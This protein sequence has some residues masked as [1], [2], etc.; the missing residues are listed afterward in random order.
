MNFDMS[1]IATGVCFCQKHGFCSFS[2][3]FNTKLKEEK[4]EEKD[5]LMNRSLNWLHCPSECLIPSFGVSQLPFVWHLISGV[6]GSV[7]MIS[8]IL[9]LYSFNAGNANK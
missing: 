5:L 3:K 2:D 1:L 4:K 7:G 6:F 8:L 9:K